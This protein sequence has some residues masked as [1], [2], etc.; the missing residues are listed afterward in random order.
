[1]LHCI[2]SPH[3]KNDPVILFTSSKRLPLEYS[4]MHHQKEEKYEHLAVFL[5]GL[6]K[7][8]IESC[9]IF[10]ISILVSKE[11]K[12]GHN[13]LILCRFRFLFLKIKQKTPEISFQSRTSN[14][15]VKC[16]DT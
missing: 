2:N 3:S 7:Q 12:I 14:S 5:L 6:W 16:Y 4:C 13:N 1:M 8:K 9:S 10:N 15:C 11:Q